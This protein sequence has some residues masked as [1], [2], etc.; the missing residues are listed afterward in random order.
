MAFGQESKGARA[1][2]APA[3]SGF[4]P[5]AL[6]YTDS[7]EEEM[8]VLYDKSAPGVPIFVSR[9]EYYAHEHDTY[10]GK[11]VAV[12]DVL[13]FNSRGELLLQRRGRQKKFNPYKLHTT[14]GGHVNAG[15]S[16]DLAMTIEC[17]EE[18]GAAL[19]IVPKDNFKTAMEKC[20]P[21]TRSVAIGFMEEDYF[22]DCATDPALQ[23]TTINDRSYFYLGLYD[24]PFSSP[25]HDSA[26]YEWMDMKTLDA[27]MARGKEQFTDGFCAH[28]TRHRRAINELTQQYCKQ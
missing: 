19:V 27:E 22:R 15:E 7:V 23:N 25:D 6:R 3:R 17:I 16:P 18:V 14:V 1:R 26:G 24:G 9:T 28:V 21:Y 5:G 12:V 11:F 2:S 4:L 20:A 8:I 13:L 10:R